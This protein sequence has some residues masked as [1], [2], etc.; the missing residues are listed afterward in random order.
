[1]LLEIIKSAKYT[2]IRFKIYNPKYLYSY[3]SRTLGRDSLTKK[4]KKNSNII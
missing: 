2:Y 3:L 1:M 4:Q